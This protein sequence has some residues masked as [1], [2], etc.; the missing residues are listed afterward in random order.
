MSALKVIPL[1][2]DEAMWKS[3]NPILRKYELSVVLMPD[4]DCKYKIGDGVH[5]FD[6]LEYTD[7]IS[8]IPIIHLYHPH[9]N[10]V[11]VKI[12]MNPYYEEDYSYDGD[13]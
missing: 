13:A 5:T 3:V 12:Y 2:D 10:T 7:K 11:M 8:D 4:G 9:S 6:E 1:R